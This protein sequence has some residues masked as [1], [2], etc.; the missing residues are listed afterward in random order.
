MSGDLFE[1]TIIAAMTLPILVIK[2][3][4]LVEKR[5]SKKR[6][7]KNSALGNDDYEDMLKPITDEILSITSAHRVAY[8]AAQN[9]E[10]TLDG[11]SIKKLSL[12]CESNAEGV[13]PTKSQMQDV[14]TAAFKRNMD[15]LKKVD[16]LYS[17]EW[18]KH[19]ELGSI[20]R[21]YGMNECYY[22]K[23]CNL[24]N[25]IWTG[26]LV[27]GFNHENS[28]LKEEQMGLLL[29]AVKRIEAIISK[30]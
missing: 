17:K 19:D 21:A 14:P 28:E 13:P 6:Y 3:L 23:V 15:A 27:V 16:Y 29:V 18:E 4:E 10:K 7:I 5:R 25:N 1:K 2:I 22:F 8:W 30:I 9:G 11:F 12:V 24:K 26:I 20:H